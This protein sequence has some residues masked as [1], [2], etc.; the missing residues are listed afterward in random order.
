MKLI[1][2]KFYKIELE[3]EKNLLVV[4]WNS[5]SEDMSKDDFKEQ[6]TKQTD[7]TIDKMITFVCIDARNFYFT[8][9]P[10]L[11]EW[12]NNEQIPRAIKAGLKKIATITPSDLF[13]EVSVEQTME[14]ETAKTIESNYFDNKAS[15]LEWLLS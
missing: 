8:I 2:N 13:S 6:Q 10:D 3:A 15:A 1:E 9:T 7:F 5:L 14:E 4:T 12:T 11:Q